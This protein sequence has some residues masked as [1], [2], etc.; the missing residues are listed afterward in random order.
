MP[1]R[2]DL[3]EFLTN[4]SQFSTLL[5]IPTP[6]PEKVTNSSLFAPNFPHFIHKSPTSWEAL[7]LRKTTT[8]GHFT[9]RLHKWFADLE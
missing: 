4:Q 1:E 6:A 8:V 2:K 5:L 9:A 7:S 3:E